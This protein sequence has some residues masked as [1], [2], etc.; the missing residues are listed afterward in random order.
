MT[1]SSLLLAHAHF[2]FIFKEFLAADS[3]LAQSP[4]V[5]RR[6]MLSMS[7]IDLEAAALQQPVELERMTTLDD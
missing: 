4:H 3:V 5:L 1:S 2:A 6:N 7:D